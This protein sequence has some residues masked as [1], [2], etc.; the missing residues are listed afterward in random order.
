V[1]Y[2]HIP[3]IIIR[4]VCARVLYFINWRKRRSNSEER[5][6]ESCAINPSFHFQS[7]LVHYKRKMYRRG[8]NER[9]KEHV[10]VFCLFYGL[11]V[12]YARYQ[13]YAIFSVFRAPNSVTGP[14]GSAGF[15]VPASLRHGALNAMRAWSLWHRFIVRHIVCVGKTELVRE[16]FAGDLLGQST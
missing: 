5:I 7:D 2:F 8:V 4:Y 9:R 11:T 14:V 10:C 15:W 6:M 13:Q 3:C 12:F 16:L 1:L